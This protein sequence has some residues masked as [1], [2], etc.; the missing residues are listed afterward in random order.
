[1]KRNDPNWELIVATLREFVKLRKLG[2]D[3][4]TAHKLAV[5]TVLG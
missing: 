1:M 2:L 5:E 4:A 3:R